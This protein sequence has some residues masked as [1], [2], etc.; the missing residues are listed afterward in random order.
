MI[1][2]VNTLNQVLIE[3]MCTVMLLR[4]FIL[5]L[6]CLVVGMNEVHPF[7]VYVYVRYN[8]TEMP[9]TVNMG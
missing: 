7:R 9:T 4:G 5:L 6:L 8:K 2:C 1:S 3:Y